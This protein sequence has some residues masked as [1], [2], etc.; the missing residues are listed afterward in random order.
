MVV[1]RDERKQVSKCTLFECEV[2]EQVVFWSMG[3]MPIE[4]LRHIMNGYYIFRKST[5]HS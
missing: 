1:S 3:R 5:I 2:V 4:L